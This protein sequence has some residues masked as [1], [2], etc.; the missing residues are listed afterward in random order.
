MRE[1][2][3]VRAKHR[4]KE[5]FAKQESPRAK[6]TERRKESMKRKKKSGIAIKSVQVKPHIWE[7]VYL[8]C[9]VSSHALRHRFEALT[10]MQV[11]RGSMHQVGHS[12]PGQKNQACRFGQVPSLNQINRVHRKYEPSKTNVFSTEGF[13]FILSPSAHGPF[14]TP[15]CWTWGLKAQSV[16]GCFCSRAFY[17][18]AIIYWLAT[19]P[20]ST[21]LCSHSNY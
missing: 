19:A 15:G 4:I 16:G 1:K 17:T 5:L 12:L 14:R 3:R 21:W 11:N 18:T 13:F 2:R 7:N 9:T 6:V 10:H 8:F 20:L